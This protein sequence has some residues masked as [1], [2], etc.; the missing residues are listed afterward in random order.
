MFELLAWDCGLNSQL[1]AQ[2]HQIVFLEDAVFQGRIKAGVG[3]GAV[4][5]MR[6]PHR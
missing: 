3:T 1:F 6:A 5:K 4:L 2:P